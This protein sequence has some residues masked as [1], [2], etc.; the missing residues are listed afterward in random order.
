MKKGKIK[1]RIGDIFLCNP[2]CDCRN[3]GFFMVISEEDSS[4]DC[5]YLYIHDLEERRFSSTFVGIEDELVCRY[6]P[7]QKKDL[8]D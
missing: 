7:E 6:E 1:S 8:M 4:D 3:C 2:S 5:T